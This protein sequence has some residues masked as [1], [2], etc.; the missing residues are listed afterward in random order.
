MRG[1][2]SELPQRIQK[3]GV[4]APQAEAAQM[5]ANAKAFRQLHVVGGG[6]V[7][8]LVENAGS[9]LKMSS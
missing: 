5:P 2:R 9:D 7:R 6:G 4:V 3:T 8:E 1:R